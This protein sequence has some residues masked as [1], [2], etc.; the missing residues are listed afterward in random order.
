MIFCLRQTQ[1]KCI[2]Q[3]MPLYAAFINF[4]K[5]FETVSSDGLLQVLTKFGCSAKFVNIVKSLHSE[6]Q[7]SVAQGT[8]HSNEFAV[9]N[10]V[11]QGCI[12]APTLF[13]LYLS[14]MLGVAFDDSLD[15]VS[16]QT[17]HKAD[18]FKFL[19]LKRE[20]KHHKR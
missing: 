10:G 8:N 3:N 20:Q 18:L 7:A 6:M 13:S 4:T 16:I 19:T 12:L 2:E 15:G 14:T 11:K 9:T 17:Q 1:K 5:A